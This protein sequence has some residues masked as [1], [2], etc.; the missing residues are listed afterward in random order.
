MYN[1][2]PSVADLTVNTNAAPNTTNTV[3]VIP[4]AGAG[5]A[6]RV[7]G[8]RIA[9]LPNGTGKLRGQFIDSL[10]GTI[11]HLQFQPGSSDEC[12][13]PEPGVQISNNGA[14][15]VLE[16]SDVATQNLRMS[17]YYYVD[18]VA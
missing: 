18:A 4:A 13:F 5:F 9:G 12:M 1:S 6:I 15:Q 3:T 2:P 7:A 10:G 17:V 11:A 8:I 14:L 16:S